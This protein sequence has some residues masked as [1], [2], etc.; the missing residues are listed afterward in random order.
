[1]E[2]PKK[3][4]DYDGVVHSMCA[5]LG[6]RASLQ[7]PVPPR[8]QSIQQQ[9]KYISDPALSLAQFHQQSQMSD[10]DSDLGATDDEDDERAKEMERKKNKLAATSSYLGL[11]REQQAAAQATR[12]VITKRDTAQ[13]G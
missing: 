8:E 11:T 9:V 1:M 10:S 5:L 2:I 4:A 13:G 3:F 6:E 12:R 7:N